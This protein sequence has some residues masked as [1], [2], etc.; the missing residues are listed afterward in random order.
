ME[1]LGVLG[2]ITNCL[3]LKDDKNV[4]KRDNS[5]I[6]IKKDHLISE[7]LKI[8]R[9]QIGRFYISLGIFFKISTPACIMLQSQCQTQL[10][11][12][13]LQFYLW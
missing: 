10:L 7:I 9:W 11:H 8:W 6:S 3:Y 13:K 12:T 5:L 2:R 4:K 1:K